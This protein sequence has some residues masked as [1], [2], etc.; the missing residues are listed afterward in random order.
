[1]INVINGNLSV[2]FLLEKA[3]LLFEDFSIDHVICFDQD[4]D[5]CVVIYTAE[6]RNFNA[7]IAKNYLQNNDSLPELTGITYEMSG[8][9]SEKLIEKA[10]GFIEDKMHVK[11]NSCFYFDAH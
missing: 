5:F 1:M 4:D 2:Y 6:K 11:N 9:I 8:S 7:L 3:N 10:V